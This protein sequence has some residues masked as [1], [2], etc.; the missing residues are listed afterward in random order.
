[1]THHVECVAVLE[2]LPALA[3]TGRHTRPASAHRRAVS[4][5]TPSSL[6]DWPGRVRAGGQLL[7]KGCL[8]RVNNGASTS[9]SS[10]SP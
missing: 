3:T 9:S 10:H 6:A 1:M 8:F 7:G 2:L 4:G 5:L